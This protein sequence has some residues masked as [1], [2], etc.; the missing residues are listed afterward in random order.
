[1]AEELQRDKAW[2]EKQVQVFE[3]VAKNYFLS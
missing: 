3:T 1:M 2:A